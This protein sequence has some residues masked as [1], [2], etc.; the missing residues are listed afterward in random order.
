M[1]APTCLSEKSSQGP[2]VMRQSQLG[3]KIE[4]DIKV[5]NNAFSSPFWDT[6][7]A[8]FLTKP[9]WAGFVLFPSSTGI[10]LGTDL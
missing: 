6:A 3:G 10:S 7:R 1:H 9:H 2:L 8:I 4:A 5:F